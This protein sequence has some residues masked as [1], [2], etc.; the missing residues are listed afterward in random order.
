MIEPTNIC[1]YRCPVCVTGENYDKRNKGNM[2][3]GQFKKVVSPVKS[4]LES[5]NL[6]GF[7]EPFLAP[8]IMKMI[9]YLGE[10]D[11]FINIHTNGSILSKKMMNQFRKNYQVMITF[12]IDGLTQKTYGHYRRGGNLSKVM[13]NLS[14]LA[15]LKK[16]YNLFN[17]QTIW[18]F[19]VMRPNEHE[20]DKVERAAR[21]IGVDRLR[22]KTISVN[23]K[24]ASYDDLI[25]SDKKYQREG[26]KIVN[27]NNCAFLFPGIPNV[28]WDGKVVPCCHDYSQ[29]YVMGNA[30]KENIVDIWNSWKYKKFRSDYKKGI[31]SLCNEKCKFTKKSMIYAKE[32]KFYQEE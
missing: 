31:N 1:N 10:N 23:K 18:Q 28:S 13:S 4:S 20:V 7:G 11:I 3:F 32:I 19:L 26:E 17:L 22:L 2:S 25:P 8:D 30:I 14:Y 24:H 27:E 6:W 9:N 12:S 5:I 29:D 21:K 15:G 16:K